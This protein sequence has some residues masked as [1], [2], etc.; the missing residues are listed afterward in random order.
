[1]YS[2]IRFAFI[3]TLAIDNAQASHQC[4]QGQGTCPNIGNQQAYC[5][6]YVESPN[7]NFLMT[8][9]APQLNSAPGAKHICILGSICNL[10]P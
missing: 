10:P 9:T 6:T 5:G 1:M 4:V 8:A 7:L 2:K 3:S